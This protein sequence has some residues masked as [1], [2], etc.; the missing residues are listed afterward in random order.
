MFTIRCPNCS[1]EHDFHTGVGF[2][3]LSSGEEFEYVQR[4]CPGCQRIRSQSTPPPRGEDQ[5]CPECGVK[6]EDWEGRVWFER[7]E[8]RDTSYE[9]VE[10]PCPQCG[11]AI[12]L[13]NATLFGLWD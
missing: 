1:A 10:G 12:S 2:Y 11:T 3:L 8:E 5:G 13:E 7:D 9:Q 6:L 4:V